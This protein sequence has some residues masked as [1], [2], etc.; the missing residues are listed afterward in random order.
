MA[1]RPLAFGIR[2]RDKGRTLRVRVSDGGGRGYLVE[3]ACGGRPTRRREHASLAS[4]LRDF[5]ATW[6]GRLH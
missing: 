3:D 6:R 5:S 2:F 4:A 1:G